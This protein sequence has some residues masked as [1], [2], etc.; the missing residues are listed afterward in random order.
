MSEENSPK[1]MKDELHEMISEKNLIEENIIKLES[2]HVNLKNKLMNQDKTI[3]E[4]TLEMKLDEI[5]LKNQHEIDILQE[6]NKK[7]ENFIS[8]L[9]KKYELELKY[10]EQYCEH[11]SKIHKIGEKYPFINLDEIKKLEK[12][13]VS[14][15]LQS[16]KKNNNTYQLNEKS[17]IHKS[18]DSQEI[19]NN[20]PP[21]PPPP[22]NELVKNNTSNNIQISKNNHLENIVRNPNITKGN[23][24]I[25]KTGSLEEQL[26]LAF[27][28]KYK[29]LKPSS[30][31]SDDEDDNSFN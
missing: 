11:K 21:P 14:E 30:E 28:T 19:I 25:R 31:N 20:Q 10:I 22:S 26:K 17:D 1:N 13:Y 24:D 6:K 5:K 15:F 9:S 2:M 12:S 16:P 29:G 23:Y 4:K 8:I 18:I 27:N 7:I 3:N